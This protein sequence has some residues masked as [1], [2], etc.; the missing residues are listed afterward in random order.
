MN[1]NSLKKKAFIDTVTALMHDSITK[2][3]RLENSEIIR[4][5]AN[6]EA[7]SYFI[8]L[9]QAEKSINDYLYYGKF[10]KS[11]REHRKKLLLSILGRLMSCD[12]I[13]NGEVYRPRLSY[14]L[15]NFKAPSF[16]I[17]V[18]YARKLFYDK[19]SEL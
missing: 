11:I 9:A 5:A 16:F 14:V 13:R 17:S 6:H 19:S 10:T 15:T 8:S 1:Q 12:G 4:I 7:P 3:L 18:S 2:G